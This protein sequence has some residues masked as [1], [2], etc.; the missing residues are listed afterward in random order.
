MTI[1]DDPRQVVDMRDVVNGGALRWRSHFQA[2][3][4]RSSLHS[5]PSSR[6]MPVQG[7]DP[8][9]SSLSLRVA[10]VVPERKFGPTFGMLKGVRLD[11]AKSSS[12]I[13]TQCSPSIQPTLKR[14]EP[15]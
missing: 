5:P 1:A 14:S 4:P 12:I 10:G 2:S 7:Y 15:I 9:S 6:P 13:W 3:V 8:R 11:I